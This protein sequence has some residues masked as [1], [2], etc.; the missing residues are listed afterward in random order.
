MFGPER[1]DAGCLKRGFII[2]TTYRITY[3]YGEK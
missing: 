2:C 1:E 3:Y